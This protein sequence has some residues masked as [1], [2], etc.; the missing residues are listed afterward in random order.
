LKV[1]PNNEVMHI[2]SVNER[3]I[4]VGL[5]TGPVQVF[6]NF[7]FFRTLDQVDQMCSCTMFSSKV[8]LIGSNQKVY[9][10][11]AESLELVHEVSTSD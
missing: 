7:Q 11:L 8:V 5:K 9:T 1:F 3:Y 10:L 2:A 6:D 4:L